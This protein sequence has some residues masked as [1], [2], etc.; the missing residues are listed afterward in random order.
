MEF[1]NLEKNDRL[2][3]GLESLLGP[4]SQKGEK[5]L[6]LDIEKIIPAKNQP[7]KH[8]EEKALEELATS[9][10][11][12]GVLQPILVKSNG[13][14]Y[15]IIAGERRWRAAGLAGLHKIPALLKTPKS[16]ED[17]FWTLLENLQRENLNPL[18]EAKA[19]LMLLKSHHLS[20]QE[21]SDILGKSRPSLVNTLRLLKLAP[22]IQTWVAEGRLSMGLA[23]ELLRVKSEKEQ[24]RLAE[25]CLQN[26]WTVKEL[27]KNLAPT[28]KQ[29][30]SPL[31]S[32]TK[33][34]VSRLEKRFSHRIHLNFKK[35]KGQIS[36]HFK[37]EDELK[38]LVEKLCQKTSHF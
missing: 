26:Q 12:H 6:S 34:L 7:R 13:T 27:R 21:L 19:Y 4:I 20:Q 10:K 24:K 3:Q 1:Q 5:V 25:K 16:G 31:P 22:S 8:F 35:G 36:F 9:I 14:N 15:E 18:E 33:G 37:S 38:K 30:K 17:H 11:K 29:P 23:K 32:W 28:E 2:G